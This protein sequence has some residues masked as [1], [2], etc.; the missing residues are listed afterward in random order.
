ME[1]DAKGHHTM[2]SQGDVSEERAGER[3]DDIYGN[4]Q[5]ADLYSPKEIGSLSLQWNTVFIEMWN[6]YVYI[7][8]NHI[9]L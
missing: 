1:G 7:E 3:L 6:L 9:S 8:I 5:T 2:A 4:M